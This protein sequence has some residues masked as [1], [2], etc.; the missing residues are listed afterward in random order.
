MLKLPDLADKSVLPVPVEPVEDGVRP[1]SPGSAQELSD[2][3]T[4][5]VIHDPELNRAIEYNR[6]YAND[7]LVTDSQRL[8]LEQTL[9]KLALMQ[10][11]VGH[12][13]FNLLGFDDMLRFAEQV[14]DIGAFSSNELNFL[15]EIFHTDAKRYGFFGEKVI[16]S[17]TNSISA[18]EV[19]KIEGSGHFLYQGEPLEKF[20]SL[21]R[22]V[23]NQLMLTSGVRNVVKQTYLFLA[24]TRETGGNLSRASR[25]VAPPGFSYHGV[26]DFDVGK[27]GLGQRNFTSAFS[28]TAEF[29]RMTSL[30]YIDIRYKNNNNL[31]VRF[32]PWH[33]KIA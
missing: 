7:V 28:S 2:V 14:P 27:L 4:E 18:Q 8:L 10:N 26:G 29:R 22:D 3:S 24:K 33:V 11:Y 9:A 13:N 12:G 20:R 6:N 21:Q 25:S 5:P 30:G 17:L 31:G 16:H 32:E 23:G 19:M 15:D 1:Y